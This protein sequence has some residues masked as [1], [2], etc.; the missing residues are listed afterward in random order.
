VILVQTN[1][2]RLN[3]GAGAA[4][5]AASS[6]APTDVTLRSSL[7]P[8][9]GVT[10]SS[11]LGPPAWPPLA[12]SGGPAASPSPILLS[13]PMGNTAE[14]WSGSS[15]GGVHICTCGRDTLDLK[16]TIRQAGK[17]TG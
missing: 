16:L 5:E 1:D 15:T 8:R 12:A 17:K 13:G 3:R 4:T 11:S 9:L 7:R 10:S 6:L 2:P 14:G